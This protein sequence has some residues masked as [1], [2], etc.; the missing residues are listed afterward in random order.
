MKGIN[1][2]IGATCFF[3]FF[4]SFFFVPVYGC[5][6]FGL[7]FPLVETYAM[8]LLFLCFL[9]DGW[10]SPLLSIGVCVKTLF[11]FF[12]LSFFLHLQGPAGAASSSHR[13]G[14]GGIVL[15]G[16]YGGAAGFWVEVGCGGRAG[17]GGGGGG[18]RQQ[19]QPGKRPSLSPLM[20]FFFCVCI[21]TAVVEHGDGGY[22]RLQRDALSD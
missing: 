2:S 19:Q 18:R 9:V 7:W 5:L 15:A 21:F 17:V 22:L 11:S 1:Q 3:F 16:G 20:I 12:F 4:S 8:I 13:G 10:M 6:R 14:G